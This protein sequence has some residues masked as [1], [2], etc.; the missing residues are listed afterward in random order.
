MFTSDSVV[1]SED[2]PL[3]D[4]EDDDSFAV[5]APAKTTPSESF[6]LNER[7]QRPLIC[8]K[9]VTRSGGATATTNNNNLLLT[10]GGSL[11]KMNLEINAMSAN[12]Q[13]D[14]DYLNEMETEK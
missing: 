12:S 8:D 6:L 2:V 11:H 4:E 9:K 7:P 13:Y 3:K 14:L 10:R 5:D 1:D